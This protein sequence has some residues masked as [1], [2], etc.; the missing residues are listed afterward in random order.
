[1]DL[2]KTPRMKLRTNGIYILL[3][4]SA[5]A[6]ASAFITYYNT[7]EKEQSMHTVIRR[8]NS[9]AIFHKFTFPFERHGGRSTG[10]YHLR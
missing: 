1:M 6:I 9:I 8:Y 5:A 10:L 4:L 3:R 7:L 2:L